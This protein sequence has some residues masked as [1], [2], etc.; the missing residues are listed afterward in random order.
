MKKKVIKLENSLSLDKETI[1]RLNE[2]QLGQLEGG[3]A[4]GG[5]NTCA[6]LAEEGFQTGP[7]CDACSCNG[8]VG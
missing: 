6:R 2:E 5:T 1:S 3:M 8:P 7:S 4:A